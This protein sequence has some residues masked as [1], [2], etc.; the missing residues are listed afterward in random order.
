MSD[1]IVISVVF[2]IRIKTQFVLLA[3]RRRLGY[4]LSIRIVRCFKRVKINCALDAKKR[5]VRSGQSIP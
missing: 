5:N 2:I 1:Y 4:A 3:A